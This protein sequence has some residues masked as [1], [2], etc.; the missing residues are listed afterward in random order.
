[1]P[2]PVPQTTVQPVV[3]P[4]AAPVVDPK[5]KVEP[6]TPTEIRKMKLKIQDEEIEMGEDEVIKLAQKGKFA[7]KQIKKLHRQTSVLLIWFVV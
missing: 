2:D 7:D 3:D 1:M 4:K 5:A 6:V